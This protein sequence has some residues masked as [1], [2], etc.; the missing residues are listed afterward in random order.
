MRIT[1][2]C[3]SL[4]KRFEGCELTSYKDG[5][6]VWTIGY[7]HTYGAH[8]NQTITQAQ[9]EEML[10]QDLTYALQGVQKLVKVP[11]TDN[12]CAAL[13]SLF[14]NV[15][16]YALHSS[17]LVEKLNSGDFQGCADEFL[18]WDHINGQVSQG[19]LNRREAERRLFLTT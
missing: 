11:L 1:P 14:F 5:G 15:G 17:H 16:A 8:P 3:I 9:A 6:G 12:Q 19:L 13:V 7:G 4:V 2:A 18:K 10:E